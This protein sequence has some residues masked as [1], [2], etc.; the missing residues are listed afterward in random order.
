MATRHVTYQFQDGL[1]ATYDRQTEQ[2]LIDAVEA[3]NKY[4]AK[5]DTTVEE[6]AAIDEG[7]LGLDIVDD[8]LHIEYLEATE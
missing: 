5:A 3:E 2:E 4:I 8:T 1:F 7:V 6:R